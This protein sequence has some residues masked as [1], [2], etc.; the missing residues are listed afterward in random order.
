MIPKRN[1]DDW[2]KGWLEYTDN[3][4]PS[5]LFRKWVA[6]STVASAIQRKCVI[7]MGFEEFYANQYIV[8]IG[9]SGSRKSTA[10]RPAR[11]MIEDIGLHISAEKITHEQLIRRLKDAGNNITISSSGRIEMHASLTI[12]SSELVVFLGRNNPSFLDTLND[13]WD[14][15]KTWTY[16]T[17]QSGKDYIKNVWVNLIGATTPSLLQA[18]LPP[19]AIGGGF[20]SRV[21]FI[22]SETKGKIVPIPYLT[23]D[24]EKL[25]IMLKEDL[26]NIKLL[27]GEFKL[28]DDFLDIYINWTIKES[29]KKPISDPRFSSYCDKRR[30]HLLKLAMVLNISRCN[31]M[32]IIADDFNNALKWLE[33]IEPTMIYALS[34]VG[35]SDK[36]S[37]V[38]D[39]MQII[40]INKAVTFAEIM[41]R[42]WYN[43]S[44]FELKEIIRTLVSMNFC[45]EVHEGGHTY[46]EYTPNRGKKNGV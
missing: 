24:Q 23:A 7:K 33:E 25:G 41:Q 35:M 29:E 31:D 38:S 16:E 40:R 28:S 45:K 4:E 19:E 27:S 1:C 21:I 2:I 20:T 30:T 3:T 13:W 26:E 36:A 8:L 22:Y 12:H 46:I 18:S 42:N 5:I 32:I 15:K 37:V 14:A 6:V 17:K 9:P 39:T 34:A 44:D 10:M 11:D 43:V